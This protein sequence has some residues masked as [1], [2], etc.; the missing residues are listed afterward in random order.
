MASDTPRRHL[1]K[2]SIRRDANELSLEDLGELIGSALGCSLEVSDDDRY[3]TVV[4]EGKVFGMQLTLGEWYGIGRTRTFQ[5]H[6]ET[7]GVSAP[8]A[9]RVR[10]VLDDAV[11]ELLDANGAGAWR[12]PS[13]EE[14]AAESDYEAERSERED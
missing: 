6:G 14:L 9:D 1:L 11:I 5:L 2:F 10:V 7:S 4:L 8:T 12:T 3:G 13:D